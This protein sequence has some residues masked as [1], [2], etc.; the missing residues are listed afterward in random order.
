MRFEPGRGVDGG[1]ASTSERD[2]REEGATIRL[3]ADTD[4]G[5]IDLLVE[6]LQRLALYRPSEQHA[7][8]ALIEKADSVQP[9]F[10][11][12]GVD[13]GQRGCDVFR[14]RSL[15]FPDEAKRDVQ[16]ILALPGP[17]GRAAGDGVE[18]MA[19]EDDRRP[20]RDE[21]A[22]HGAVVSRMADLRRP[23]FLEQGANIADISQSEGLSFTK[24]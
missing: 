18:A 5:P 11:S 17:A 7:L 3:H 14:H 8:A 23:V 1:L 19:A 15:N 2:V 10:D 24:E 16:L 21:Q 12:R 4:Q 13:R 22:M 6:R 9:E 20:E